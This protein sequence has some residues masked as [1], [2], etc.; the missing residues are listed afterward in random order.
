MIANRRIFKPIIVAIE[1]SSGMEVER[2]EE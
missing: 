1:S 2:L